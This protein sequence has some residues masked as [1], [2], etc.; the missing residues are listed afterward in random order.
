MRLE[1]VCAHITDG[2][3]GDCENKTDSGF[4]FL[5]C[6]DVSDGAIHYE[7]ARQITE[8]DFRD[9]HRRTKLE[10][11]DILITNS[12]TIG[13]MALAPANDLTSRTTFQKSVAILKPI[14]EKANPRFLFYM[15]QAE[16]DR[17]IAF[18]GGTA[19]K[20]LLLRDLRAFKV[21]VPCLSTQCHV[22]SILSAYD[23]LI[24]NNTRR[25]KILEQMVQMLYQE[26]FI[27][28]R[29]PGHEK[30]KMVESELGP[31]PQD[32]TVK[33]L[34]DVVKLE[35]GKALKAE[36]RTGGRIPV[37][38]SSGVVGYH[39]EKLVPGPGIVVGRK[40]NVGSV[41]FCDRDFWVI[42]TAYYVVTSM[43]LHYIYFN[44]LTQN[45]L[46]NDAAVPG[47]NR[48]QAHS[49]PIVVPD[50]D[51]LDAFENIVEPMFKMKV[52]L[53]TR[54]ANLRQTRDLLLPK[55]VSGDVS[56]GQLE[57]EAVAQT[58]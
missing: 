45:F 10:P 50:T 57:T 24:E 52:C 48:N 4:Y 9:T 47:L 7:D 3:H 23:D 16:R 26:W 22:A 34:G 27:D 55:L 41:F 18:A 38:G 11:W 13:R 40:G 31:I 17:L 53:E 42:D 15:L 29:F 54:N 25:I 39:S 56:V 43:P 12:G 2:K 21:N 46:N 30:V 1:E 32:W 36:D 33:K 14:K 58:V 6:K 49:L 8:A 19:Q 44:L 35:Y 5:S 37:F 28:F 20:N 51:T